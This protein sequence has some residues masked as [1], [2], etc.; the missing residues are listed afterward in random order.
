MIQCYKN[1]TPQVAQNAYVHP[2]AVL[3]GDVTVGEHSSI[4]PNTTLRGDDGS[5]TIGKNTSIQDGTVVHLTSDLS[6][7]TVE[8]CVTV[9]HNV[10][11]HGCHV[12]EGALI[13]MGAILLDNVR[14]G[15]HSLVGAGAL[16]LQR[17][18]IPPYSLVLG[19]PAKV[20]RQLTEDEI[21]NLQSS[22][23]H[24]VERTQYYL[25]H[26]K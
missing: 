17:M 2:S 11:L 19:N 6:S 15:H 21:K 24:Y 1:K 23:E 7:T 4:W 10:I 5:I 22:W 3:I 14:V 25:E 16:V 8:D 20:V 9:G 12:E 13:G 26:V 18:E